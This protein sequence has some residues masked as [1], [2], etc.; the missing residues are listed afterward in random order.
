MKTKSDLVGER[1]RLGIIRR[2]NHI[3][4][5]GLHGYDEDGNRK[6][7]AVSPGVCR[8]VAHDLRRLADL[9]EAE[10]E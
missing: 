10:Y 2:V 1:I 3:V 5:T 6:R 7:L 8:R 9:I 4:I